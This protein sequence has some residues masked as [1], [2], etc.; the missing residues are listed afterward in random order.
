M[1]FTSIPVLAVVVGLVGCAADTRPEPQQTTQ[2]KLLAPKALFSATASDTT[3]ATLGISEWRIYRGKTDYV[4][5]GHDA[6]GKPVQGT[7]I[8]FVK[9]ESGNSVLRARA[10][11][12]TFFAGK[13][14]FD[15]TSAGS[16]NS[17]ADANTT[18]FFHSALVDMNRVRVAVAAKSA[19][20]Q[21]GALPAG[22]DPFATQ[23]GALGASC[24]GDLSSMLMGALQCLSQQN[25]LSSTTTVNSALLQ[26]CA[27]ASQGAATS[28]NTCAPGADPS[29]LGLGLG[30]IPFDPSSVLAGLGGGF[31][32]DPLGMGIP[33]GG[34]CP[35]CMGGA[36]GGIGGIGGT[37]GDPWGSMGAL[38]GIGMDPM[39]MGDPF[40]GGSCMS[41]QGGGYN[42]LSM[43]AMNGGVD[44]GGMGMGS[45]GMGGDM[46][47]GGGDMGGAGGGFGAGY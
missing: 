25:G 18:S 40:G 5:S 20:A 35:I 10:L 21:G 38:G 24:G 22:V 29:G 43:D 23:F 4:L 11:N 33:A 9:D 47:M 6:N 31:G 8:A 1:R 26:Q 17:A 45:A 44:C 36:A 15:T 39:G 3:K 28:V 12:G 14:V 2:A 41:C 32:T 13:H 7:S 42:D 46:G 37:S 16:A 30:N 34:A 27:L 19:V